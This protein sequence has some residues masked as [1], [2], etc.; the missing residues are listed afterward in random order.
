MKPRFAISTYTARYGWYI[1]VRQVTGTRTARYWMVSSKIDRRRS[2][3]REI[4]RQGSIEEEK[5]KKKR[6]RR[7]K[8]AENTSLACRPRLRVTGARGRGR[9][10]SLMRR[11]SVSPREEKDRGDAAEFRTSTDN[12]SVHRY[13]P[14]KGDTRKQVYRALIRLLQD[15]DI[16]VKV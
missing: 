7:K 13:R 8:E 16:A 14:I 2:I 12:M 1:P 5:G 9:F 11:R 3:E 4:D 15:N 10:F 6:K